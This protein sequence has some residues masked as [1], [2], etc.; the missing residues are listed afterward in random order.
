MR[1][2]G[3]QMRNILVAR[4]ILS[5]TRVTDQ[6]ANRKK[7]NPLQ[8]VIVDALQL[9]AT[10]RPYSSYAIRQ[11]ITPLM[12][13][14]GLTLLVH[15]SVATTCSNDFTDWQQLNANCKFR[16]QIAVNSTE[17]LIENWVDIS[18][19]VCFTSIIQLEIESRVALWYKCFFLLVCCCLCPFGLT[20]ICV[21]CV[22]RVVCS[23]VV[24]GRASVTVYCIANGDNMPQCSLGCTL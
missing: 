5:T 22:V 14:M 18:F 7:V 10:L 13:C 4:W 21:V 11:F 3:P 6:T 15:F 16:W 20:L 24:V 2:Y 17:K 12:K 23:V 9:F 1:S 8:N 19:S